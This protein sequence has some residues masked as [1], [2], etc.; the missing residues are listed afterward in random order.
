MALISPCRVVAPMAVKRG[1]GTNAY[2]RPDQPTRIHPE[3]LQR[4]YSISS[5][6]ASS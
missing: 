6:S 5:T 1:M 4:G 2:A 3:V